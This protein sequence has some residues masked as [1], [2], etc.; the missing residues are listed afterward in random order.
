MQSVIKRMT[1]RIQI[2]VGKKRR[3]KLWPK[4][5]NRHIELYPQCAVCDGVKKT[6]VHHIKDF[7]ENPELELE[8]SN[9]ITLCMKKRCHIFLGHLNNFKSINPDILNDAQYWNRKIRN[10]R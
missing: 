2:H 1:D 3:S 6:Q 5:R 9:L 7:S 8:L 10:R 4:V